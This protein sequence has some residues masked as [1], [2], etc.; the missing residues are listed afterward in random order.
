MSVCVSYV[1]ICQVYMNALC[2]QMLMSESMLSD[3]NVF[4]C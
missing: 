4:V 2:Y 1:N 3:V